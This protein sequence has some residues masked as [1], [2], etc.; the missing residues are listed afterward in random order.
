M[1]C[2]WSV[3]EWCLNVVYLPYMI[4]IS[5]M[6][7]IYWIFWWYL[8]YP[9]PKICSAAWT[10]GQWS[11]EIPIPTH[12]GSKVAVLFDIGPAKHWTLKGIRHWCTMTKYIRLNIFA[13]FS[14][15]Q[16]Q[17]SSWNNTKQKTG[18]QKTSTSANN[19]DMMERMVGSTKSLLNNP[20]LRKNDFTS[21]YTFRQILLLW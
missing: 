14:G 10:A 21:L 11:C 8:Y 1:S 15:L 19:G 3:G 12:G 2:K 4:Y 17:L 20:L 9:E 6:V 5:Y 7:S 13:S 18:C 16:T